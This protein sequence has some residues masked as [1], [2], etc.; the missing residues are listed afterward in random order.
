MEQNRT[1]GQRSYSIKR[2]ATE[3]ISTEKENKKKM[4]EYYPHIRKVYIL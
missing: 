3:L 2:A 1:V 4:P